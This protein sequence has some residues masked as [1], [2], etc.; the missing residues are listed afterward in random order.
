MSAK[1]SFQG[2][3]IIFQSEGP[4]ERLKEAKTTKLKSLVKSA[5]I[6][7][8][9][10]DPTE[11]TIYLYE[12][13]S[14]YVEQQCSVNVYREILPTL[15]H[16]FPDLIISTPDKIKSYCRYSVMQRRTDLLR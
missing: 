4:K 14:R 3:G 12:L 10:V 13:G 9:L 8:Q 15:Q 6:Y 1:R 11:F 7:S 16:Q 2:K 5:S